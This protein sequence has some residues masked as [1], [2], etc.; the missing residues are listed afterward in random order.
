[1]QKRKKEHI[2]SINFLDHYKTKLAST[3]FLLPINVNRKLSSLSALSKRCSKTKV[4]DVL[5]QKNVF[6]LRAS[7]KSLANP[8]SPVWE[9]NLG[10]ILPSVLLI[11]SI[12]KK[13]KKWILERKALEDFLFQ[14]QDIYL[15]LP[16]AERKNSKLRSLH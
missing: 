3:I 5:F 6:L 11:H 15:K 8:N 7:Q 9:Q 14:I 13:M 10:T 12:D 4:G 2:K 1:M 16:L